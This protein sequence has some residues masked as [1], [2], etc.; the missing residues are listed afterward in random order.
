MAAADSNQPIRILII[1]DDA[2][3]AYILEKFLK[4]SSSPKE[5]FE[6][7]RADRLQTGL[8]AL[9]K[10]EFRLVL[11]DLTLPDSQGLETFIRVREAVPTVPVVIC[12]GLS[13]RS[14]AIEAISKG[15]QDYVIKGDLDPRML[16]RVVHYALERRRVQELKEEFIGMVVH[17]LRSPLAIS[18]EVVNQILE[19]FHGQI[20]PAQGQFLSM[21]ARAMGRLNRM[22]S[23]LLEMT[24]IELGKMELEKVRVNM[25]D[26]VRDVAKGFGTLSEKK[27]IAL[28]LRIPENSVILP[29]DQDKINQ[30]W[31]NLISNAL[32]FT[33]RGSIEL[34][35]EDHGSEVECSVWDTGR[36]I[37]KKDL[38]KLFT[39]FERLGSKTEGTGL[40]LVISKAVVEAHGGKIRAESTPD[41]GTR[42]I[43]TLPKN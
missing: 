4:Q 9:A 30:V 18:L 2:D 31:M 19:G 34:I 38:E 35:V 13:D 12:S 41:Q 17:D 43:F 8:A 11:L 6:T 39:K 1:E 7:V 20:T 29:A 42:I 32:K 3:D 33:E 15:A 28:K 22:V 14:L 5:S 36:G 16:E 23:D 21:A 25:C 10:G 24:K 37:P 27:G 40:G 26:I